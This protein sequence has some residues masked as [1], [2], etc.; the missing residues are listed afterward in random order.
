M[1][2]R[3]TLTWTPH[4]RLQWGGSLGTP[5]L[6]IF[7]NTIRYAYGTSGASPSAASL[8]AA[9]TAV[10]TDLTQWFVD[11]DS[12]I[13]QAANLEYLK[14][15]HVLSNGKQRDAVVAEATLPTAAHGANVST[16]PIWEQSYCL[17]LRTNVPKGRASNGRIFPPLSGPPP[18]AN[19][20]YCGDADAAAMASRFATFL[21]N[22]SHSIQNTVEAGGAHGFFAVFSPGDSTKGTSPLFN[23]YK[24][25]ACDEVADIQH[26][27]VNRVPRKEAAVATIAA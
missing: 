22:A 16:T 9:A 7:S 20:P 17:T 18:A 21:T 19:S 1:V 11:S 12:K 8:K 26:R 4:L 24:K 15:T 6:D 27:R 14:V 25:V 23:Y 10:M 13:G 3:M 5:P 2:L